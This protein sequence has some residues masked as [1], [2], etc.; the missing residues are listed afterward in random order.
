MKFLATPSLSWPLKLRV[1]GQLKT[2]LE[3]KEAGLSSP[4]LKTAVHTILVM[5]WSLERYKL[6]IRKASGRKQGNE[7]PHEVNLRSDNTILESSLLRLKGSRYLF[8]D[9][10]S[11]QQ[12]C[13]FIYAHFILR[14]GPVFRMRIYQWHAGHWPWHQVTHRK[15]NSVESMIYKIIPPWEPTM[16]I[17]GINS[18]W[19]FL[20]F[21]EVQLR[22]WAGLH[23]AFT[24]WVSTNAWLIQIVN[25]HW[26][27]SKLAFVT[28]Q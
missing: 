20:L 27:L 26:M 21:Y 17:L 15:S 2:H 14:T 8:C 1:V 16:S 19:W 18:T 12:G 25:V 13:F 9:S 5:F 3:Q 23:F 7:V 10:E 4:G 24:C 28:L 6:A 11:F 22:R